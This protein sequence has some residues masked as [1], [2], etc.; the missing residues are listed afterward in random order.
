[1][2]AKADL[3]TTISADM[4][5]FAAT[6]RRAGGVA[7]STGVGIGKSLSSATS[8]IGGIVKSAGAA[9]IKL[10]ALG[11][12]AASVGLVAGIKSAADLGGKLADLSARTGIAAGDLAKLGRAFEDNGVSAD[13]IGG[14]INKLQK[15]ITDFGN[16]STSAAKPFAALGIKFEDI[17][18]LDPAAQFELIQSKIAA[19]QSPTERAAV[20]MQLFGKS[21]G[22]LLTLFADTEAFANAGTFLGTQAEILDRSA[23]LFD[24]ISDKMA[25]IP[26]KLQGFFVGFLEAI[27]GDIDAILTKFESFDFAALGLKLGEMFAETID[28]IKGMFQALDLGEI[29]E[30]AGLT[31]KNAF[32]ESV[33]F[34]AKGI[35]AVI[36]MF[37]GGEAGEMF[38]TIGM[39]LRQALL[40]AGADLL[41]SLEPIL[42]ERAKV[43]AYVNRATA[44]VIDAELEAK[45][46]E[47]T[48]EP[49][50][51]EKFQKNFEAAGD[52]MKMP[53]EDAKRFTELGD[54]IAEAADEYGRIR[55]QDKKSRQKEAEDNKKAAA[56]RTKNAAEEKAAA[57]AKAAKDSYKVPQIDGTTYGPPAPK[58]KAEEMGPPKEL[59]NGASSRVFGEAARPS[60]RVFGQAG[61]TLGGGNIFDRDRARLGLEDGLTTGS[62]QT[63]SLG[64]KRRLNT[65]A[66]DR[67][68]KRNLSLQEQQVASLQSIETKIGQAITVN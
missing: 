64:E 16:G 38:D 10:A 37:K 49:S 52:V 44:D 61:A 63:G 24:S 21:G 66:D 2:A 50:F 48:G 4:T 25:R 29:F 35:S 46:A 12:A 58:V 22:E 8:A 11:V 18:R 56:S 28:N 62:L 26:E 67:A 51:F 41:E 32:I 13:K 54:R 43:G 1:M 39:K 34:L 55:E 20:A 42:G 47:K 23:G 65:S 17:S 5:G 40:L 31:L 57:A 68:K 14:V 33:N 3:K 60:R 59:M 19:I 27:G 45:A 30:Y 7:K 15:T 53:E 6:M 36:E 9:T